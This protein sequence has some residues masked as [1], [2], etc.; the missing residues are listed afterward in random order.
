MRVLILGGTGQLGKGFVTSLTDSGTIYS[1]ET[2]SLGIAGAR[3]LPRNVDIADLRALR[4]TV[5]EYQPDWIINA[6][7]YTQVDA[8]EL[9]PY[10]AISTNAGGAANGECPEF[11]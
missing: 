3:V 11:D 1:A 8:S 4:E 10:E 5:T 2:N 7:A 9:D 6:A